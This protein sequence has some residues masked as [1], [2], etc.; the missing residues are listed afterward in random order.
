MKVNSNNPSVEL[1]AY[2]KQVRQTQAKG[3][4]SPAKPAPAANQEGGDKV[5]LSDKARQLQQ[6]S[7]AAKSEPDVDMKKVQQVKMEVEKGTYNVVGAQVATDMMRES[8]ENNL[9]LQKVNTKV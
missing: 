1:N 9:I 8:F 2:L 3:N 5:V 6:A 4:E 7:Q